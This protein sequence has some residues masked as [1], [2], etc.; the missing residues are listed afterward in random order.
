MP[1]RS[2][3][4][5]AAALRKGDFDRA[6]YFHGPEDVLKE[7]ALRYLLE[8]TVDPGTR[9]FNLDVRSAG[10][11]DPES[12]EALCNTLPMMAERRVVVIR[13]VEQW[14][15][16]TKAR[17]A[18][19]RYLEHPSPETIVVLVQGAGEEKED[20]EG[21]KPEDPGNGKAKGKD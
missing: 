1:S 16:K 17:A 2:R 13:D 15:R 6:Y 19:L 21:G 14:K 5:L 4:E 20:K 10:Q 8:R 12:V 3:K 18:F 7:E 11:L 9:D